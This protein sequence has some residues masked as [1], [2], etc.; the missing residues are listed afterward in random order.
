MQPKQGTTFLTVSISIDQLIQISAKEAQAAIPRIRYYTGKTASMKINLEPVGTVH[1]NRTEISDDNWGEVV[2]E[3]VL[4]ERF[5]VSSLDGIEHF[6]H[7][8]IVF[9]FSRVDE[10]SIVTAAR[11][12][13]NNADWPKTGIFAQRGKNRPNRLGLCTARL[14]ERNGRTLKVRGLDAIDGTPVLDIKPVM[15]EFLPDGEI[16]QPQWSTELMKN[17][18]KQEDK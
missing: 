10:G 18:W 7:L 6:S 3:I 11:H 16:I 13:R 4:D 17:Y 8:E 2:S 1:N 12:P 9:F 5:P 14:L 15:K